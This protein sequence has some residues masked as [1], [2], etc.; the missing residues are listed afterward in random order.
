M[1][2]TGLKPVACPGGGGPNT[3]GGEPWNPGGGDFGGGGAGGSFGPELPVPVPPVTGGGTC[4]PMPYGMGGVSI[5]ETPTYVGR[6]QPRP[7]YV[8]VTLPFAVAGYQCGA[9]VQMLKEV[10]Q[11]FGLWKRKPRPVLTHADMK[12]LRKAERVENKLK[13]LTTR[14]TDFKVVKKGR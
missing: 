6:V 5:V 2:A 13:T 9:R 10:A 4:A 1:T 7:G 12:C 8:T 14:H 3:G 11:K